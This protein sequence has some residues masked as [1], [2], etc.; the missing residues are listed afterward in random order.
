MQLHAEEQ[1][2]YNE[3][4]KREFI[5]NYSNSINTRNVCESIFNAIEDYE[6]EWGADFCTKGLSEIQPVVDSIVGFRSQS[7]VMRIT[8]LRDYC[9]WCIV[10]G[11]PGAC[12]AIENINFVGLEK[13][14]THTVASPAHLEQYLNGLCEPVTEKTSDNIYRCYYWMAFAGLSEDE[15]LNVRSCDLDFNNMV[16]R[17]GEEEY[18]I[19][20]EAVP[21]FRNCAE[22]T[23]FLY[24]HPLY[25]KDV[26]KDRADGDKILRGLKSEPK[27]QV[28]RNELSRRSTKRMKEGKVEQKLSYYRVWI[29][30]I[31]YRTYENEQMGVKPNFMGVVYR[32]N[33]TVYKLD[34]G[35]NTQEAK[36]RQ[37]ASEYLKDYKRWKLAFNK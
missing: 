2:M 15:L 35:R 20:R 37:L 21:A 26:W 30:G 36:K 6:T 3:E 25:S 34:S 16:I 29:S 17:C 13:M 12:D 5:N 19:Y 9:R 14:K 18:P 11:V 4:L 10:Q 8:V 23:Q 1:A 33:N 22:L 24:K 31:F 7:K 32:H 28:L 27:L